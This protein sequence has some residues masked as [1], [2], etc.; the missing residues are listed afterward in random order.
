MRYVQKFTVKLIQCEACSFLRSYV[1]PT[2]TF[3]LKEEAMEWAVGEHRYSTD[4]C[5]GDIT[6]EITKVYVI[7]WER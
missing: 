7:K 3:D 2:E 4:Y 6:V 5:T 1:L